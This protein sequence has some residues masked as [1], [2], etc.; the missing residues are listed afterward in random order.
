I[1]EKRQTAVGAAAGPAHD[2][3]RRER[4]VAARE[5]RMGLLVSPL[6]LELLERDDHLDQLLDRVDASASLA[7][8]VDG[9]VARGRMRLDALDLD[10]EMH[11]PALGRAQPQ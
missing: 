1:R 3:P 6:P 4:V 2:D 8:R 7:A 9:L 10:A 11:E 5:D